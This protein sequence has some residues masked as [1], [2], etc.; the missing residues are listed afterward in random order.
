MFM[1]LGVALFASGYLGTWMI[2]VALSIVTDHAFAE[3]PRSHYGF[4]VAPSW[5]DRA[6]GVFTTNRVNFGGFDI[7]LILFRYSGNIADRLW[8]YLVLKLKWAT[9]KQLEEYYKPKKW[10]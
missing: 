7:W 5:L 2:P 3:I 6:G 10:I 1:M 4:A 8:R 9:H